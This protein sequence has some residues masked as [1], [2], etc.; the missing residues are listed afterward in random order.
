M[1]LRAIAIAI[2]LAFSVAAP[3]VAQNVSATINGTVRDSSG[4]VIPGATVTLT[5][6]LTNASRSTKSNA[7]GYFVFPDLLA[8]AYALSVDMTGFRPTVRVASA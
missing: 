1:K 4:A 2:C 5:N 6:E 3:L 8:G 7:E